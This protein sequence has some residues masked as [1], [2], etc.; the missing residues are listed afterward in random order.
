MI[1]WSRIDELRDEVGSEDFAEIAV[2]FLSEIEEA[3][4][5]LPGITDPVSRS[6]ALHGM[7]GSALNVGF[8]ALAE[9]CKSGEVNPETVDMPQLNA[10]LDQSM[11]ALRSKYPDLA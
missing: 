1:D 7:K 10:T 6:E 8:Q 11:T 9:I 2:L 3:A 4:R 5:A